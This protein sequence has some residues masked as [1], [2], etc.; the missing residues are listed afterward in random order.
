MSNLF[1]Y[2]FFQAAKKKKTFVILININFG[3]KHD[4]IEEQKI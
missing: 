1:T 3:N 4:H 2:L